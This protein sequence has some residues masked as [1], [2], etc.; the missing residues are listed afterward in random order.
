MEEESRVGMENVWMETWEV[1][2]VYS[3][4]LMVMVTNIVKITLL[5][6]LLRGRSFT[7]VV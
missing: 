6:H 3:L 2:S 5:D 7:A 1:R 4:D